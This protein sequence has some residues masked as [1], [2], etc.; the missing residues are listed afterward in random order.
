MRL[1]HIVRMWETPA[2]LK[3]LKVQFDAAVAEA[4]SAGIS[5]TE[6]AESAGSQ[7]KEQEAR[8]HSS[9]RKKQHPGIHSLGRGISP[10]AG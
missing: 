6:S 10:A 2:A 4:R 5:W 9:T 1:L 3:K 7:G 8:G